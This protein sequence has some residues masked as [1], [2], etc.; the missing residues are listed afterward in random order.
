MPG[1][2]STRRIVPVGL[3]DRGMTTLELRFPYKT[4]AIA[5]DTSAR[6]NAA[7]ECGAA[8]VPI[9]PLSPAAPEELPFPCAPLPPATERSRI[10]R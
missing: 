8:I 2:R 4:R 6:A 10:E 3:L 7:S 1:R 5:P 9:A